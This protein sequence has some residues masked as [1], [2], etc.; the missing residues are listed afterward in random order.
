MIIEGRNAVIEALRGEV[1]VEKVLLQK[2][3]QNQNVKT[4]LSLCR[5]KKVP[6]QFVDKFA[7][8]RVSNTGEHRGFIAV[9]TDY[10][11]SELDELTVKHGKKPRLLILLDGLED[12]HNFGAIIRVAD[13]AGAD[14]IVIP[15]RRNCGVTDTVVKVSSG[16]ASHVR[17]AKVPNIN[18]AIRQLKEEGYTVLAADMDGDSV[19]DA[20]LKGDVAIVIGGEGEGVH[21]LTKKLC[22]GAISLPQKGK[23]N[24][25]N[26]SVACGILLYECVR[27]R[28][29]R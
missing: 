8:E 11:Y 15:R 19:Y 22:D 25:L 18:D 10:K 24:S 27:Q 3:A 6:V 20:D 9:A 5:E 13:C 28:G 23:V 14:G 16:A 7:L 1:T 21:Q 12:P 26:A 29:G 2:D 4:V 17:V